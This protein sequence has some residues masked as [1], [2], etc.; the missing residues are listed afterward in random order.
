MYISIHST[1]KHQGKQILKPHSKNY[2]EPFSEAGTQGQELK[3]GMI[4]TI[5]LHCADVIRNLS[6]AATVPSLKKDS[7]SFNMVLRSS[8][9]SINL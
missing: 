5:S 8:Y 3:L 4:T 2:Y 7:L 9:F 6:I 1:E